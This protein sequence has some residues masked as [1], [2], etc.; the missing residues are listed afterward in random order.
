MQ[1][2]KH[3]LQMA[4]GSRRSE[5]GMH[6][7]EPTSRFT[8]MSTARTKGHVRRKSGLGGTSFSLHKNM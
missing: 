6:L 3:T 4:V 2:Y 1:A 7:T 8:H 5:P